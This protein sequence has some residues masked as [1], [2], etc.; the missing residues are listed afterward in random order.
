[1]SP[2][3][4]G[5]LG[6][7]LLLILL[8]LGMPITF[9]MMFVGFT[10]IWFLSG[11]DA[12]LPI[13]ASTLYETVS[14]YPFT[15][16]PLFVLM[17]GFADN[18]GITTRLYDTFDKWF[19]RLP[20]GL[21]IATIVA[22][23]GFSAISGSSVATS[24]AFAKTVIPEMRRYNYAPKF[25]G[26]IVAAGATI[27][28]LIPPSI[29][30]VVYGMLTEQ[31]IGKLLIAGMLP[32]LL[33][34]ALFIGII[35][36]WVKI[37]PSV[38]PVP[39]G[40]ATWKEKIFALWGM[41]ETILVFMITIGGMYLG[42][43]NP[44]EAGGIGCIALLIITLL[45]RELSW[46]QFVGSLYETTRVTCMVMFLVAGAS[47]FSYFLALSTIPAQAS[48]WIGGLGVSR[49]MVLLIVVC[50][51]L[52][53]G[54]FLDAVSMMVLTMPVI[55]PVMIGLNFDPIWF[56]VICVLMM[57]AGLITPP[58]GLNVYT[59]AGIVRDVPMKEVF[60]GATPFLIAIFVTTLILTFFPI[61]ATIL[62][63]QMGR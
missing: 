28:F 52:V 48:M 55:F 44:T 19:R 47:L 22:I 13:V 4:V 34:A 30:F 31:S 29:G 5:I 8:F 14:H 43:V 61:I 33:L 57:N 46:K 2:V 24:A 39:P 1:L 18:S 54:C 42:Y 35:I 38:A 16:I 36:G 51:Y 49:Y 21:G 37:D 15:I 10:G 40:R 17:G 27:D 50:I 7:C 60:K 11:I 26:G 62:P 41:W 58:V 56:G 12:A 25:A 3:T 32:G 6:C 53:L 45:K 23:A 59:I 9:V 20:G 63:A